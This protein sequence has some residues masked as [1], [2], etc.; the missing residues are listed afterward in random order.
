LSNLWIFLILLYGIFKG[1][2][3]ALKKKNT[4]KNSVIEVLFF[5]T[6]FGFFMTIPISRDVFSLSFRMHL[7]ILFKS[8]II[9][10]AWLCALN[11]IKRLP[12][13]VYSVVDTLRAVF[14]IILGVAFLKETVSLNQG[15]GI[16]LVLT[17]V[18]LVNLT[19]R[20]GSNDRI[21]VKLLCLMLIS[22][23]LNALS[24]MTDKWLLSTEITD[25]FFIGTEV[26]ESAQ[27]QMW[28]MLYMAAFY[29]LYILIKREKINFKRCVK[30]P[31]IWLMSLLFIIADRAL[32]IANESPNSTIVVMTVI[33]QSSILI[34]VLLGKLIFKEQNII[35]RLLCASLVVLGIVI[36]VI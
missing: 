5:Y 27:M 13:S 36:S 12:I 17:G 33:K 14:S 29:G 2:R 1:L 35:K 30:D 19:S 8:F 10:V 31:Y 32:F 25:R 11:S 21:S 16:A 24:G 15:I 22:C 3:E 34:T 7:V 28:Y 9:F 6:L 20:K 26:V 18:T 4:E 23:M